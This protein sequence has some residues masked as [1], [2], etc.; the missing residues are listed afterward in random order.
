MQQCECP[1]CNSCRVVHDDTCDQDD[2]GICGCLCANDGRINTEY[3]YLCADCYD[4]YDT[5]GFFEESDNPHDGSEWDSNDGD[6][7]NFN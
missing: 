6:W 2:D 4:W 5:N 1:G 7:E 3:G